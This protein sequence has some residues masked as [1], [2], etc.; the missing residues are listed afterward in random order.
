MEDTGEL[1]EKGKKL[2]IRTGN[3]ELGQLFYPEEGALKKYRKLAADKPDEWRVGF[4][5]AS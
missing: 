4:D 3:Y 1:D 5:S 2:K